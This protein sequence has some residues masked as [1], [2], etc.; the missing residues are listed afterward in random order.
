MNSSLIA[1]RFTLLLLCTF[2]RAAL[3]AQNFLPGELNTLPTWMQ[4]AITDQKAVPNVL[5]KRAPEH[6][7]AF[8]GTWSIQ[9]DRGK[10][11]DF[12]SDKQRVVITE[13]TPAGERKKLYYIDL[14]ANVRIN[15]GM[16]KGQ[17]FAVVED[18]HMPQAGYFREVWSDSIHATGR[19]KELLNT[20]CTEVRGTN[21]NGDTV[22]YWRTEKHPTLFADLRVWAPW[23]CREGDLE[24]LTALCDEPAGASLRAQWAAGRH[25]GSA[26]TIE[27]L[28]I[29]PG[30]APMPTLEQKATL[31]AEHRFY[32][33]NNS[34]I[35]ILPAWMR[36]YV[37]PL[38][39]DSL[40]AA[41]TPKPVKRDIPDNKFIGTLT[42]ERPSMII[43]LPDPKTGRDTTFMLAKYSYWADARRAVLIM[44]DANDE[45]YLFFAVDLD[46]DVV[47]AAHNEGHSHVVPKLYIHDLEKVGLAEFGRGV[48]VE[49][50]PTGMMRTIVGREC[51][52]YTSN[53]RYLSR[54]WFPKKE[55]L[56]PV[57]DMKHWMVQGIGQKMKDLMIFGVAD[58][59]MPMAVMGTEITSYKLGVSKPPVVDLSLY[60]VRDE[61]IEQQAR[62]QRNEQMVIPEVRY[63]EHSE[64]VEMAIEPGEQLVTDE[65]M[66]IPE[67][68]APREVSGSGSGV[69]NGPV[70]AKLSPEL[71]TVMARTTNQFIG[72]ALMEYNL[73]TNDGIPYAWTVRYA[74]TADRM[75]IIGHQPGA[76]PAKRTYALVLDRS[77]GTQTRYML[78]A[79]STVAVHESKLGTQY[80]SP[81][82]P[83]Q[84][85][86]ITTI[87][88]KIL[89]RQ[90][91]R[92]VYETTGTRRETWVDKKTPSLFL[93]ILSALKGWGDADEMVAGG[94]LSSTSDGMLLEAEYQN[95][96]Q[97]L[98]MR[99]LELKPG[100]VDPKMFE[101]T[102][103]SWKP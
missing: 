64:M 76:L 57:F 62:K 91:V 79:D 82:V 23:L 86:S 71:E 90:A 41:Y 2:F 63:S 53:E 10:R 27:F 38:K 46:A 32:W 68:V 19:T 93:D 51:E 39:Q 61:R 31:I 99:V 97:H 24:Y 30:A 15:V 52:L 92:G 72:S 40:P 95:D 11:Y 33:M 14:A 100:A 67:P 45:G 85:D 103:E 96:H 74:S 18:L 84:S 50:T 7:N 78:R 22:H 36:A 66:M 54:F 35:G 17:T 12:W 16:E 81:R 8:I 94:S 3:F 47:M 37:S 59:P 98:K 48:D 102:K 89:G 77:A 56:N 9:N 75:V 49:L 73:T 34:G 83:A 5:A 26:G 21:P 25:T 29:T 87:R 88:R 43:G 58:K 28:S 55:T 65:P 69:G 60:R 70:R 44:D 13:F 1:G 42:A 6:T 101:I 80:T 4:S 20:T